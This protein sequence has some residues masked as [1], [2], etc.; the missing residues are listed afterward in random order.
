MNKISERQNEERQMNFLFVQRE[1]Y[2][3]AKKYFIWRTTIALVFATIGPIITSLNDEIGI[4]IGITA[5]AYLLIDNLFL[6]RIESSKRLN[7]AKIQELFD[8]YLFEL[9]WNKFVAGKKP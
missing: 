6:E 9:P 3:G 4:Y 8:T 7:A 2:S 1:L 5:I